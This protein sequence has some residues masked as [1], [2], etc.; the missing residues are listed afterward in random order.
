MRD[1]NHTAPAEAFSPD[2]DRGGLDAPAPLPEW[3]VQFLT[4]LILFLREHLPQHRAPRV[5]SWWHDRPDLPPGSLQAL[6]A[7]IR[8]EFGNAIAW[9]CLR[10]GIG[11]GHPEW[12][13][14]SHAIV[15]FG[16]SLKGFRAGQPA[17][18]LQWW[19][20]PEITPDMIGMAAATPAAT[21]MARMLARQAIVHAPPPP[22]I[23][24][25]AETAHTASPA[26]R[27][28]IFARATAGPPTG[29][30]GNRDRQFCHA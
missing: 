3:L 15:A 21:A 5:P 30:P 17:R 2:A 10:R 9:M 22:P 13:E 16:G 23:V 19:E 29:P 27:W 11:P 20:N 18:G 25:P 14:F 4:W 12:P 7:S 1:L 26:P 24:V 6:A 28:R 8:G